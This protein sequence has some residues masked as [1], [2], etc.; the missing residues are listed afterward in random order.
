MRLPLSAISEVEPLSSMSYFKE[1]GQQAKRAKL[2]HEGSPCLSVFFSCSYLY[3]LLESISLIHILSIM[4]M[5]PHVIIVITT[6]FIP[7]FL[8]EY[9]LF[10]YFVIIVRKSFLF[11]NCACLDSIKKANQHDNF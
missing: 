2:E 5:I 7:F 10:F 11:G 3:L 1:Y 6:S 8:S 4:T 9:R